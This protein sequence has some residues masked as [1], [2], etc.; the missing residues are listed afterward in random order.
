MNA[1]QFKGKWMQFKGERKQQWGKFMEND[2]Q[3]TEGSYD[4]IIGL[5][6]ERYGGNCVSLV[7]ER[8]GEKKDELM[9]WADERQQRSQPEGTN[10]MTR[11]GEV[12]KKLLIA[13]TVTFHLRRI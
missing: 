7:R 9:K 8:Y 11:R 10:E 1:D 2:L 6:Q 3:Q 12:I 13:N 4:K 5:L